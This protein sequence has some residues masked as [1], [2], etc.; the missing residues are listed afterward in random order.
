MRTKVEIFYEELYVCLSYYFFLMH[1]LTYSL[2]RRSSNASSSAG[3]QEHTLSNALF[4][5]CILKEATKHV[6]HLR[7]GASQYSKQSN[8][9]AQKTYYSSQNL[10]CIIKGERR[11]HRKMIYTKMYLK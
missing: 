2:W 9:A 8:S 3:M 5:I 4:C 7:G 1:S 6:A 11:P 10:V